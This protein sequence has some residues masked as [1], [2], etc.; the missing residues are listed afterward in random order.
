MCFIVAAFF[1]A[2]ANTWAK[3]STEVG[4]ANTVACLSDVGSV[5]WGSHGVLSISVVCVFGTPSADVK[6]CVPL[7]SALHNIRRNVHRVMQTRIGSHC[8]QSQRD[9]RSLI[10]L[11][12]PS[13][14][15][16]LTCKSGFVYFTAVFDVIIRSL[17][18]SP[19]FLT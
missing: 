10:R 3:P 5:C 18:A 13:P 1:K 16:K 8:A 7:C 9:C 17:F 19:P 2:I 6:P 15:G 12:S 11:V 14:L 4:Q